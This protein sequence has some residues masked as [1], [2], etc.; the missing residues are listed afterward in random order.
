MK[1]GRICIKFHK[2]IA[3]AVL[4]YGSESWAQNRSERKIGTAEMQFLRCVYGHMLTNHVCNATL[5]NAL[6]IY[7]SEEGIQVA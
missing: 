2:V 7:D 4:M 5:C 6:Q 3:A 1:L